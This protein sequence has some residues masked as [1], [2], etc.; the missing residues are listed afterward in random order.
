MSANAIGDGANF[1]IKSYTGPTREYMLWRQ[2][3]SAGTYERALD[4]DLAALTAYTPSSGFLSLAKEERG[5]SRAVLESNHD[6]AGWKNDNLTEATNGRRVSVCIGDGTN[7][8]VYNPDVALA[9][10]VVLMR[11]KML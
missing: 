8:R 5:G 7:A 3:C 2:N 10:W 11:A 6:I 9:E 4:T 1:R